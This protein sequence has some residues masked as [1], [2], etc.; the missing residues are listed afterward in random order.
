MNMLYPEK[1]ERARVCR[2]NNDA[3]DHKDGERCTAVQYECHHRG[4][5]QR[6]RV[7]KTAAGTAAVKATA[8]GATAVKA[9]A[10]GARQQRGRQQLG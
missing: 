9:T 3:T 1:Q 10:V 4:W 6:H 8:S 7:R 2:A 5:K